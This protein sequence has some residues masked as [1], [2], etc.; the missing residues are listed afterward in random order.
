[1]ALTG[2]RDML[3]RPLG[4]DDLAIC[5]AFLELLSRKTVQWHW[6]CPCQSR[7][8]L[9]YCHYPLVE[10]VHHRTTLPTRRFL[11]ARAREHLAARTAG[12]D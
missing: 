7:R 3:A 10:R 11:L 8:S 6:P 5:V 12:K 1:M 9:R 2:G 4:F